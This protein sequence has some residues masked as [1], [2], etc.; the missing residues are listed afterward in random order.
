MFSKVSHIYTYL[1]CPPTHPS[2]SPQ[3]TSQPTNSITI[4]HP[5]VSVIVVMC[6]L[7][8]YAAQPSGRFVP[9]I[10]CLFT[11]A[12]GEISSNMYC[13][14]KR[15][16]FLKFYKLRSTVVSL[17]QYGQPC[18]NFLPKF[19]PVLCFDVIHWVFVDKS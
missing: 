6:I 17:P 11:V 15:E 5:V 12:G 1:P 3:L 10:I 8:V 14:F 7:I 13:R 19:I 4:G 18:F 9:V 16:L 2:P